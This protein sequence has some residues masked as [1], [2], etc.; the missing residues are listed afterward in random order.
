[1]ASFLIVEARTHD[2]IN[3]ALLSQARS[4]LK[5]A[6]HDVDV[7][8]APGVAELPAVISIALESDRYDGF[9]ALGVAILE[10]DLMADIIA[11][12]CARALI[13]FS[14]DGLPI[15]NGVVVAENEEDACKIAD[16]AHGNKGAAAAR[17]AAALYDLKEQFS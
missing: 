15:G 13:A 11:G 3:D 12:E 6:G 5:A 9:L 14:L 16:P 4:V 10:D 7:I 17:S 2:T 1:M 8:A